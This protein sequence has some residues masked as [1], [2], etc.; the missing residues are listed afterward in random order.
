MDPVVDH[1]PGNDQFQVG[2]VKHAVVVGVAVAD[3]DH[4]QVV[5]LEREPV[6]RDCRRGDL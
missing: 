4:H 5:A 6:V 1:V 2:D 3:V